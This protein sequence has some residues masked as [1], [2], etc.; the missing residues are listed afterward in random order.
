LSQLKSA[1]DTEHAA[2]STSTNV[3]SHVIAGDWPSG[4]ALIQA[5]RP[6]VDQAEELADNFGPAWASVMHKAT[7][8]ANAFGKARLNPDAL[9]TTIFR[10]ADKSDLLTMSA[11]ASAVAPYVSNEEVLRILRYSPEKIK[12]IQSEKS[13]ENSFILG[14]VP[15][16][17]PGE[18]EAEK[19]AADAGEK[20]AA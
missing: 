15:G 18:T 16:E 14:T 7:E 2:L 6:L 4:E 8:I 19:G 12:Q 9:I 5:D 1:L 20:I 11:V 3:P 13:D 17:V 10:P